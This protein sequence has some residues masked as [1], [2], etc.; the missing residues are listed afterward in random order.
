MIRRIVDS[1]S[2][3]GKDSFHPFVGDI[4]EYAEK[5][6]TIGV[7]DSLLMPTPSP[8]ILVNKQVINLLWKYD[9]DKHEFVFDYL[10][11]KYSL[12]SNVCFA[13]YA[14][15][16]LLT[17]KDI[18]NC[19]TAINF[20]FV[21]LVHPIFD[22]IQYIDQLL[23][24]KP[25]AIKIHGIASGLS[26][27]NIPVDF[28]NLVKEYDI[29]II[30]H[31]DYDSAQ[32]ESPISNAWTL[33]YLRNANTPSNW[34]KFATKMGIRLYLTHGVRLDSDS[35]RLVN[36]TDLFVVGIGPDSLI[37]IEP[38]RLYNSTFD[39]LKELCDQ[40]SINKLCFDLDYPWNV[41]K[42]ISELT[43]QSIDLDFGGVQ[44]LQALG[45][46]Q[47]ELDNIL[48]KNAVRFFKI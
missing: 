28:A 35:I 45:L 19:P 7:T 42:P 21:P 6:T 9:F 24:T 36:S 27:E 34:I 40:V 3:I 44:R 5:A 39:Y 31:T 46:S 1:H 22:S 48:W 37:R 41:N 23:D 12:N 47:N 8:K 17:K 30:V 20:H 13:P 25:R 11:T 14:L 15:A 2:H 10:G 4:N 18:M 29:P 26:P 16:N 43:N 32:V 33:N 38:S